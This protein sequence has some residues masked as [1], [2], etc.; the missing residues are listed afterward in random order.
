MKSEVH[1]Q[2]GM[3]CEIDIAVEVVGLGTIGRDVEL[4]V[5]RVA[6]EMKMV[7]FVDMREVE[8]TS[9]CCRYTT[10]YQDICTPWQ[11][12]GT[13]RSIGDFINIFANLCTCGCTNLPWNWLSDIQTSYARRYY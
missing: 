9:T 13:V 1:K 2:N 6:I 10:H 8:K 11:T 4:E 5:R 12:W 3:N 7:E